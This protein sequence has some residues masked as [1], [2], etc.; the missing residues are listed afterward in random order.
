MC[1]ALSHSPVPQAH[2]FDTTQQLA[3]TKD[4]PF[5]PH[6]RQCRHIH[7]TVFIA[8]NRKLSDA[9]MD[10]PEPDTP[11]SAVTAQTTKY[12]RVSYFLG[13]HRAFNRRRA[14]IYMRRRTNKPNRLLED[15]IFANALRRCSKHT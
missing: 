12:G 15:G 6:H 11:F 7:D 10:A 4:A 8:Q 1:A 5:R 14:I 9:A 2:D 3:P 13:G